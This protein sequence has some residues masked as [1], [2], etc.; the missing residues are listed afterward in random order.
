MA[1]TY[2]SFLAFADWFESLDDNPRLIDDCVHAGDRI[3]RLPLILR[4][5][6]SLESVQD[7]IDDPSLYA[8]ILMQAGR[9]SL[10]VAQGDQLIVSKQIQKYMVRMSQGKA[11]LTYLNQKGKSRLGSRIRLR[12]SQQFFAEINER[13]MGWSKE[14]ELERLFLSC[15]PKLKGAWFQSP[16]PSP[17][18]KKDPR[19]RRIPFMV[20]LPKEEELF[21][22]HRLLCRATW[23]EEERTE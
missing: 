7:E 8:I 16:E 1:K 6:T 15:T 12:Q 19:W 9:A 22:I 23:M 3:C 5:R 17:F 18:S 14:Y 11:Q 2:G 13:L 21:R 20:H 10:A 4:D